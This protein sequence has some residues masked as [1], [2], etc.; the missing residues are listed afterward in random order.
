MA[1]GVKKGGKKNRKYGRDLKKCAAYKAHQ[2]REKHKIKHMLVSNGIEF[3]K[4]WAREHH[5]EE[6]LARYI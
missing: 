1:D 2:V 3:A 6:L 4:E 5:A